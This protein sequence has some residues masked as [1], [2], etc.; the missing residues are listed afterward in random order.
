MDARSLA[1]TLVTPKWCRRAVPKG[2]VKAIANLDLGSTESKL[3]APGMFGTWA[4]VLTGLCFWDLFGLIFG[5]IWGQIWRP[6]LG[7][8]FGSNLAKIGLLWS[9]GQI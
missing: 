2:T 7:L 1:E 8:K 3:S 6:N 5:Q 9:F 4:Q